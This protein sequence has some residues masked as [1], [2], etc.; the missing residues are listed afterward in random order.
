MSERRVL[1]WAFTYVLVSAG[2]ELILSSIPLSG[3]Q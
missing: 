2:I 1:M 3:G